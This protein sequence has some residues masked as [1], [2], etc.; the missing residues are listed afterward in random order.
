[1][2]CC[3]V[4][5]GLACPSPPQTISQSLFGLPTAWGLL[6]FKPVVT[7]STKQRMTQNSQ[8]L[9]P[10]AQAHSCS[11]SSSSCRPEQTAQCFRSCRMVERAAGAAES[12]SYPRSARCRLR[13][14]PS[15][16]HQQCRTHDQHLPGAGPRGPCLP[17][18]APLPMLTSVDSPC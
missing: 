4:H 15:N 7:P 11:S 5:S 10:V 9:L 17:H 12:G 2:T 16:S 1:M 3:P 18:A 13:T 6:R 8:L 14:I